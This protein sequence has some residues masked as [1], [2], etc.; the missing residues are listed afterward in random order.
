MNLRHIPEAIEA[1]E[2]VLRVTPDDREIKLKLAE[3]LEAAGDLKRALE[4]VHQG[5]ALC[6]CSEESHLLITYTSILLVLHQRAEGPSYDQ[7][8]AEQGQGDDELFFR[9]PSGSRA[10]ITKVDRETRRLTRLEREQAELQQAQEDLAQLRLCEDAAL[11]GDQS[12]I[13]SY[14]VAAGR[15]ITRFRTSKSLYPVDRVSCD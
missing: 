4:V 11:Q 12:A 5:K 6:T 7:E 9:A 1:F 8:P 2:A 14:I 13:R 10:Q 15:M 3:A